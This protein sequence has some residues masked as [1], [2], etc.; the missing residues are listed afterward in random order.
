M[1]IPRIFQETDSKNS[2]EEITGASMR[3]SRK[4]I[5]SGFFKFTK[6]FPTM[7]TL[8]QIN[9]AMDIGPFIVFLP[10]VNGNFP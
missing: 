9:I 3:F 10:L 4:S 7:A 8:Q 6:G 1:L 5:S 2:K